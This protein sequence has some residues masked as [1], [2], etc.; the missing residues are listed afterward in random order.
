MKIKEFV[1]L[2]TPP[3]LIELGRRLRYGGS[4]EW[5]YIPEGWAYQATRGWNV[6]DV[7]E[8][9]KQKWPKFVEMTQGTGPLGLAHESSLL[10]NTDIYSHN[11]MMAFGYVLT[12]AAH[13]LDSLSVLDWGGGIGHY[14]LLAQSLA[15]N[16][17]CLDLT[18][19]FVDRLVDA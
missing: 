10:T 8:V 16:L 13:H 14:C 12:L 1:R 5:E 18:Q 9:Y 4:V 3:L 2:I 7:L 17:S 6:P 15:P 11:A 19:W